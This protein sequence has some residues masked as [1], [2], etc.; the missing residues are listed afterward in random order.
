M[1]CYH[2]C[3]S[4]CLSDLLSVLFIVLLLPSWWINVYT[5]LYT[6]STSH[7]TKCQPV[8]CVPVY[9][10]R[11]FPSM[12]QPSSFIVPVTQIMF[13]IRL[14]RHSIASRPIHP[15]CCANCN[16]KSVI[17][18]VA[19]PCIPLWQILGRTI[20]HIPYVLLR[21]SRRFTAVIVQIACRCRRRSCCIARV[22]WG[23]MFRWFPVTTIKPL[24][25]HYASSSLE[26]AEYG[27][28]V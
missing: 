23:V 26:R 2:I 3:L 13:V 21:S 17:D 9:F 12:Q 4:V 8:L 18:I 6:F 25:F 7:N 19:Q 24:H 10:M 28:G 14:L 5:I 22:Y 16:I 15:K 20:L 1:L 27:I 11:T